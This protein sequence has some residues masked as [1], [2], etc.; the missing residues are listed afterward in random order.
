MNSLIAMKVSTVEPG[1]TP[2][3]L[4]VTV[5]LPAHHVVRFERPHRFE[6]RR[7]LIALGLV[8]FAGGRIH[9]EIAQHLQHVVLHHVAQRAGLVVK[10][11]AI[12]APRNFPPS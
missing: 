11:P 3:N 6:Q 12:A 8:I 7:L 1:A 9:G 10:L 4:P 5:V 2:G